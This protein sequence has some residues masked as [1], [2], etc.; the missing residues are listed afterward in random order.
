MHSFV[1][2]ERSYKSSGPAIWPRKETKTQEFQ[3][4]LKSMQGKARHNARVCNPWSSSDGS[5]RLQ[6]RITEK[7]RKASFFH[8]ME[9]GEMTHFC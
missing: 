6:S 5:T 7:G 3:Y 2:L 9:K 4:F 1:D 8:S